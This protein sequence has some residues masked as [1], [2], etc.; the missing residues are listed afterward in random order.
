MTD[1]PTFSVVVPLYNHE[2]YIESAVE[3]VIGQTCSPHELIVVDDGST[4]A[5]H[6]VAR[7]VLANVPHARL[8]RQD[9]CGAHEAINRGIG[10]ATGSHVAIL[11]SDDLFK[12]TKLE[13]CR[14]LLRRHPRTGLIFG[15][16]EIIDSEGRFVERN[17]TT[18]WLDRCYAYLHRHENLGLALIN[19]NFAVTTS[20]FVFR[21]DL[22]EKAGGFQD[23]RYCHDLDFLM[24]ALRY[25]SI[26]FD[27]HGG[28]HV[29]YRVHPH[30]TI[31][32]TL[33]R[34]RLEIASVI[35]C[36]LKGDALHLSD[37]APQGHAQQIENL[38]RNK[39]LGDKV[40]SLIPFCGEFSERGRLYGR[41]SGNRE[42]SKL[43]S[44]APSLSEEIETDGGG[45]R[46]T[47]K[48]RT[49]PARAPS[50]ANSAASAAAGEPNRIVAAIELSNFDK[51]GLEKVVLDCAV[52]FRGHGVEPIIISAG[53]V[54][55]LGSVAR[56]MGIETVKLPSDDTA[57]F[58][59]NLLKE[60]KVDIAMSHFSHT[61]YE[62]FHKLG[63]PN[64]T[65][66]HNVY[67]MLRDKA[68]E[69]F[70]A[71]DRY[72]DRYISVSALATEYAVEKYHFD[73]KKIVTIPNGLILSEHEKRM[74]AAPAD[75]QQFGVSE[76]D[77]LF[78][79]V[80]S[81][82]L[83]KAH[84]LMADAM[85]LVLAS[86]R[87][88][89]IL[90]VGNTI[91]APHI[92]QLRHDL[93][94]W[95][96]Q[97]HILLPG[98]FDDVAP[99]HLMSD[100]FLLPSFIEGWSIAMN[101]AM[102]YGRP[103]ILTE[104][105]GAPEAIEDSDIGLLVP[106]EYGAVVNLDSYMLDRMAYEQRRFATAPYL[107]NAMMQFADNREYWRE[108]GARAH[109]KV[110]ETLDFNDVVKRYADICREVLSC[111]A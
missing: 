76:D 81:Y 89:K 45:A 102:Y 10:M 25:S 96:L 51:G 53:E 95:G 44:P 59:E 60:R 16:V 43:A 104:T 69:N 21:R 15:R 52:E 32:E 33:D 19:E 11:N 38:L 3:S 106:N 56:N 54:G 37:A 79:N 31:K 73:R 97:D 103:M 39:G 47:A 71:A 27:E 8:V 100:A 40:A 101:E 72:V 105:G 17:E 13:R 110:V 7:R 41:I 74:Q 93:R 23:L 62:L 98:Y 107:A 42:S 34:V 49:K 63:I 36:A 5:S 111:R 92:D 24:A 50:P 99:L 46:S 28:S 84:Y 12:I 20:N 55:H 6:E 88:I 58:Y 75:R 82:N 18:E 65:F 87:D 57:S 4:D 86:R 77:Y 2:R 14:R 78:L 67:A 70:L 94:E 68:L 9:N 30:N 91:F 35:A 83:H 85:K 109:R 22:W 64:I 29:S 26:L 108:R 1:S 90:C 80:A 61:G 48:R 66:I